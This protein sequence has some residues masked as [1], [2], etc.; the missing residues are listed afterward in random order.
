MK[1]LRFSGLVVLI[2]GFML[3]ASCGK[4]KDPEPSIEEKQLKL[5]V[6][7]WELTEATFGGTT[8]NR[9][10]DYQNMVLT[11]SNTD[12]ASP[13]DYSVTGLPAG[14]TPWPASGTWKFSETIPAQII[15]REDVGGDLQITT[16]VTKDLL[17]L[18][19]DYQ[20]DGFGRIS[21][22]KGQ[23]EFKFVPAN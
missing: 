6:D 19:F 22:I 5:L 16:T 12:N 1:F 15:Y 2:G 3:L 8:G 14:K 13:Y 21:A 17:V 10:T 11:I 7:T 4:G 18:S 9:T 23:W 20:G